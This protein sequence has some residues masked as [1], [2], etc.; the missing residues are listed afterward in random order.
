[1]NVCKDRSNVYATASEL[2][3]DEERTHFTPNFYSSVEKMLAHSHGNKPTWGHQSIFCLF[4]SA[5]T[6]IRSTL[7]Q[8]KCA[9]GSSAAA[10]NKIFRVLVQTVGGTYPLL[11]T[12]NKK[13]ETNNGILILQKL[14][15]QC[16]IFIF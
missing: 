1:M 13:K 2:S 4:W 3:F 16:C 11:K 10:K 5:P 14:L 6:I 15:Q 7:L 8:R 9:Y 12:E